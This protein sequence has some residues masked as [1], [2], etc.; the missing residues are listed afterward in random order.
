MTCLVAAISEDGVTWKKE[1]EIIIRNDAPKQDLG[2]P[3]SIELEPGKILSVYYQRN[4]PRGSKPRTSPPNP[5][6]TKP[7]I[8]GTLWNLPDHVG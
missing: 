5:L 8:L 1:N 4:V 6:R 3:V 2:Y 7:S